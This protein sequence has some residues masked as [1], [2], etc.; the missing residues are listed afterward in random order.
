M[1]N[2]IDNNDLKTRKLYETVGP[3]WL[4]DRADPAYTD[5]LLNVLRDYLKPC[6]KVLDICCGY[7]RLTI[8]LVKDGYDVTGI[9]ISD[10]LIFKGISL[11]Q[12]Y[13]IPQRSLFVANMKELPFQEAVFDFCFC[14]WASFNF[15]ITESEQVTFL[16]EM[17][18]ILKKGG[19]ALIECPFQQEPDDSKCIYVENVSYLYCP[20]TFDDMKRIS[21]KSPF[22]QYNVFVEPLAGRD[23]MLCLFSK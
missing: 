2:V 20:I 12:E 9:D 10:V 8:P 1:T 14:V 13:G 11:F 7:G 19:S 18:R 16:Q 22:F 5:A 3:D 17:H 23:R 6:D 15:L 4:M 21:G